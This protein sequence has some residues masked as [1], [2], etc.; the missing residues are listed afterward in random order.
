MI[1][2]IYVVPLATPKEG[3]MSYILRRIPEV[4]GIPSAP[5]APSVDLSGTFDNKRMQYNSTA[6]LAELLKVVPEDNAK[7]VGITDQDLFIPVL[8]HV[9]GEAQLGGPVAV[10]SCHRL[11]NS[12]YG[13]PDDPDTELLRL[14]KEVFH[15]LG[16][17]FNLKHCDNYSCVMH[18]STFVEDIDVK[19][20]EYCPTCF[21]LLER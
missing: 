16:H 17:T 18:S 12:F 21:S 11:R 2:I 10:A 3:S 14:E 19:F 4:F 13:L 1:S 15:E 9:F 20:P 7:V 6:L 5:F 8:T